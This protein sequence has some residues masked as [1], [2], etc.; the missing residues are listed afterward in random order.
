M[1]MMGKNILN[2]KKGSFYSRED[3]GYICYPETGRPK[4]GEWDTGYTSP[5]GFKDNLLVFMNIGVPGKT[6]H[7]FDNKYFEETNLVQWFGKPRSHSGTPTFKR[8]LNKE[9][10]PHFFARWDTKETKFLYLGIGSIIKYEDNSVTEFNKGTAIKCQVHIKDADEIFNYT[11]PNSDVGSTGNN[12][13]NPQ[14]KKISSVSE[15]S[16]LYEK[17]LEDYIEQKW[18]GISISEEYDFVGRQISTDTG[19]LDILAKRK[20]QKEYLVIE[21]K[22]DRSSDD[23]IGQTLRYMAFIQKEYCKNGEIVKGS[24]IAN[25]ADLNLRNA[26]SMIDDKIGILTYKIS[27][28]LNKL[29]IL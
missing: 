27:F 2:F 6:G 8:L 7:N 20:D 28:D 17:H 12:I 5:K 24:I 11:L 3:I 16:F 18:D 29:D 9:L 22:R 14:Q 26:I 21:L 19:P 10:T 25:N 15:S 23:V 1:N 13:I 4:G